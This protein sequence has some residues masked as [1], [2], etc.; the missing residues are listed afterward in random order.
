MDFIYGTKSKYSKVLKTYS[1]ASWLRPSSAPR[2]FAYFRAPLS[3]PM[4]RVGKG[5]VGI[6]VGWGAGSVEE[7]WRVGG[8]GG[9]VGWGVSSV[10]VCGG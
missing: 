6:G 4:C 3:Y 2:A 10:K 9:V 8:V 7:G 1:P 5:G